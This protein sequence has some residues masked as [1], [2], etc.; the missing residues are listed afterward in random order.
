MLLESFALKHYSIVV[1][2]ALNREGR[3]T[4]RRLSATV[5]RKSA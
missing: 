2:V 3:R 5:A 4:P 1:E